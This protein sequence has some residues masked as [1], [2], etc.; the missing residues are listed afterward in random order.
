MK[1]LTAYLPSLLVLLHFGFGGDVA[2]AGES[3]PVSCNLRAVSRD[4]ELNRVELTFE[5]GGNLNLDLAGKPQ[6][7]PMSVNVQMAYE[8]QIVAFPATGQGVLRSVRYYEEPKGTRQVGPT[9]PKISLPPERRLLAVN[10][11]GARTT[12]YSPQDLLDRDEL[13]LVD[14]PGNSLVI[15][16]L[17]PDKEVHVGDA[18][19]HSDTVLA[20]LLGLEKVQRQEVESTL[21]DVVGGVA[22]VQLAGK[23]SGVDCG[24]TTE[25][26]LKAKY[27]YDLSQKRITWMGLLVREHRKPGE[28]VPSFDVVARLHMQIT[29]LAAPKK[30][31]EA[32]VAS[33]PADPPLQ[34]TQ[35]RHRSADG[36][37]KLNYDRQWYVTEDDADLTLLKWLDDGERVTQVHISSL[38]QVDPAKITAMDHFKEDIH[39]GLGDSF[40]QI[41]E[42]QESTGAEKYRVL[43]VVAEGKVQ[44]VPIQWHYYLLANPQGQQVVLAFTCRAEV[45]DRLKDLESKLVGAIRFLEPGSKTQKKEQAIAE[46][47]QAPPAPRDKEAK[48][49]NEKGPVRK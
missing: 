46:R 26:E 10:V 19:H 39:H 27:Q 9:S 7:V 15:D 23:V 18:W 28:V 1:A 12:V 32:L 25:I 11:D 48:S 49:A 14:I 8:E 41:I 30:L 17:L 40:G 6:T 37:W 47:V 42:A 44:E 16:R 13:D 29:P 34:A 45:A 36:L 20:A 24:A 5:V 2:A 33:V 22:R 31:T 4:K 43:H 35:L 21:L 3:G 38:P